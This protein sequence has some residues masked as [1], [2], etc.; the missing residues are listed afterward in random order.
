[1][2]QNLSAAEARAIAKEAYIYG[3]PMAANYQT[4]YKQAI[5]TSSPD[6]RAPF[7]TLTNSSNRRHPRRQVRRH[8]QL[9]HALLLPLDGSP[10]RTHRRHHAEDRAEPLLHRPDD[11][12]LHLQLRLPRHAQLRQR[13]RQIPHRRPGME[14][15]P[16]QR[17]QS[18]HPLPKP[19]S[20]TSSSAPSSST[21]PTSPTSTRSRPATTPA[22]QHIPEPARTARRAR[23]QLAQASRRS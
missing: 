2:T 21:P 10:R 18:R 14:R 12:S 19:S 7:N 11:R 17:H 4:M 22:P 9:R 8:P 5:D 15:R 13:R 1:M 6:Y 23:R 3:F 16:P 20:P